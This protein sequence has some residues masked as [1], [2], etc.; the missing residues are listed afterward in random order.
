MKFTNSC[1]AVFLLLLVVLIGTPAKAAVLTSNHL[2][3]LGER[4]Q[5]MK[6]QYYP[7]N[8]DRMQVER[9]RRD[10]SHDE[11]NA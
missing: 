3:L 5:V 6:S 8:N 10:E 9:Q 7:D 11:R 4:P 1:L 2:K